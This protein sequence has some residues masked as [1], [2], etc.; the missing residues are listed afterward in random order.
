MATARPAEG[1]IDCDVHP[2]VPSIQALVPYLDPYWQEMVEL[3]G[4]AGFESQSFPPSAPF[5][6]RADWRGLDGRAATSV[7]DVQERLFD[8]WGT[9]T[10]VLNCLYGVQL[11]HDE[12]MAAA[13]ARAVNEWLAQEWLDADPRL[14]ASIVVP[15]QNAELA[16]DEI[17]RRAGDRRFV[18]VLVLAMG[19]VPLGR[20]VHWPI[21]A[22][23][24]R[25]GLPLLVHAGSA[26]RQ[27]VTAMG[28][29]GSWLEDYVDQPQAFQAQLASLVSHGVFQKFPA[30]KVVL[31]ESGITWLPSFLWRFSKNWRGLRMEIP[32]VDREPFAIIRD[33]VRLTLQP[34][35]APPGGEVFLRV[36]DQLGT[37]ETIL[38][39]SD[40]PHWQFEGEAPVPDW[41]PADLRRRFCVDNPLSTYPRLGD[42]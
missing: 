41:L 39:G 37:D 6:A 7:G 5:S 21:Y 38:Y 4:I 35:D 32:W 16:V 9:G 13:M 18:S 24:E 14:R 22:A 28:W 42:G 40:Y 29:P 17:E 20:R 27:P 12:A 1:A 11:I 3:R 25:H 8:R 31:G 19:E 2:N 26:Y 34:I 30:L 33:H 10:V 15:I 36:L 23:C